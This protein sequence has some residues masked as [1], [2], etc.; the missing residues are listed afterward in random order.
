V[1][2]EKLTGVAVTVIVLQ[3]SSVPRCRETGALVSRVGRV[4]DN[5]GSKGVMPAVAPVT[6]A[7]LTKPEPV[8]VTTVAVPSRIGLG[9]ATLGAVIAGAGVMLNRPV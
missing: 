7:P 6:T 9:V 5:R 2:P 3:V 1:L 8:I 4:R